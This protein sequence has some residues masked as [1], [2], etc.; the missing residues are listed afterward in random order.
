MSMTQNLRDAIWRNTNATVISNTENIRKA[1]VARIAAQ[2][3]AFERTYLEQRDGLT[4]QS[5]ELLDSLIS[6][7]RKLT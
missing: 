3:D 5:Q 1:A 6:T 4:E 7:I 2:L